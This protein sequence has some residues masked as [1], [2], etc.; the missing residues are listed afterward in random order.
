MEQPA[1]IVVDREH[2][3]RIN[4]SR[5]ATD[6]AGHMLGVAARSAILEQREDGGSGLTGKHGHTGAS[7]EGSGFRPTPSLG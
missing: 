6:H 4:T 2:N 3:A 7:L 5:T 1:G